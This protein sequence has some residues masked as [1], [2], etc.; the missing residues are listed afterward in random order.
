MQ[1]KEKG[2]RH[3]TETAHL[4]MLVLMKVV[5]VIDRS[6]TFRLTP[7]HVRRRGGRRP[8]VALPGDHGLDVNEVLT[9]V[10]QLLQPPCRVLELRAKEVEARRIEGEGQGPKSETKTSEIG[11]LPVSWSCV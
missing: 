2:A 11:N 10:Q 7:V 8:A 6:S 4:T 3:R 5:L 9:P 1:C